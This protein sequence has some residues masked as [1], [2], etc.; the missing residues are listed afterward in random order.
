LTILKASAGKIPPRD[1]YTLSDCSDGSFYVFG[2]FVHGS[3]VD[4]LFKFKPSNVNVDC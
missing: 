1:D 2:G 3:R 4:E